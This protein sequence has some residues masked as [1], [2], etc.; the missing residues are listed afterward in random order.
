V[1]ENITNSRASKDK[2]PESAR[3]LKEL[4]EG[5]NSKLDENSISMLIWFFELLDKWDREVRNH[6][7]VV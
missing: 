5:G 1:I 6:A 3:A 7:K 2:R 4:P